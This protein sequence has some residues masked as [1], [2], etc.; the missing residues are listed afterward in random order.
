[1]TTLMLS[2]YLT[3]YKFLISWFANPSISIF[4]SHRDGEPPPASH[5]SII[6]PQLYGSEYDVSPDINKLMKEKVS[7]RI[8]NLMVLQSKFLWS[9]YL[10]F[11]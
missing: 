6:F 7:F 10:F 2:V 1:M 11:R 4:F 9:L 8:Y 5:I 3:L